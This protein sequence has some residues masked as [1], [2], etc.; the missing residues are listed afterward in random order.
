[1]L[2][3]EAFEES[4][5]KSVRA[6]SYIVYKDVQERES[7]LR[8]LHIYCAAQEEHDSGSILQ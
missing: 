8:E 5:W 3:G 4:G 1:M 6:I 2:Y 7:V